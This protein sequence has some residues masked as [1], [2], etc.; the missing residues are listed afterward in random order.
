VTRLF[1]FLGV[2]TAHSSIQRIFP[3]W[4]DLLQLS[5]DVALVGWDLPIHAPRARYREAVERVR[6]D[7]ANLGGLVTTHKIDVYEAA[8]DLFAEVDSY[9]HLCHEISCLAK[10][11]GRLYGKA[12]DPI[13]AGRA[14]QRILG[15][16]YFSRTGGEVLC[17]GA[18]GAGVAITLYLL[19][20][21]EGQDLPTRITVTDRDTGRLEHLRQLQQQVAAEAV[22]EYIHSDDS[23]LNDAH[24]SQLPPASVVINATGMG[25]DT[26]GSPLSDAARFP[27]RG[28]VWELN[29][30]GA[31]DFLRQAL[32]ASA[33]RELRV[34]DGWHY[35]IIGWAA[36]IEAVFSRP[37]TPEELEALADAAAFAR[38]PSGGS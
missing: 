35:F 4:R 9:A 18:G 10:R 22:V 19:T 27:Q 30:R 3:R 11:D 14:L 28:V 8:A 7:P 36:V 16:G 12:T 23:R 37:I 25:K 6:D 33:A 1:T 24:V 17:L 2:S 5:D 38:P 15:S 26:P 29:Y 13:S 20:R 34:E 21:E 32:G 31:R